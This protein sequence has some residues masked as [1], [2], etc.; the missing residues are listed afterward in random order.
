MKLKYKII[1]LKDFEQYLKNN[2]KRHKE[3]DKFV[4][5]L[6]IE[7]SNLLDEYKIKDLETLWKFDPARLASMHGLLHSSKNRNAPLIGF[8]F[9]G[10]RVN[11]D[12]IITFG[13]IE[14]MDLQEIF[15]TEEKIGRE[16]N[17]YLLQGIGV[18]YVY[19]RKGLCK[20][21]VKIMIDKAKELFKFGRIYLESVSTI[22]NK[23]YMSNGFEVI[24][25]YKSKHSDTV[26]KFDF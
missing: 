12:N 4:S 13:Y 22:S 5:K 2:P 6:V 23:C 10:Y 17:N 18:D 9:I 16:E 15:P 19:R 24:T 3:L 1:L 26:L 8:V 11:S 25:F 14:K 20:K 7:E 21:M